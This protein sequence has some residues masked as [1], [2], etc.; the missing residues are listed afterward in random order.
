[1][2]TK[3]ERKT[4]CLI[5]NGKVAANDVLRAAVARQREAGHRIDVRVTWEKGDARR[6]V[7]ETG[8]VN[9]LIAAGGAAAIYAVLTRSST[10]G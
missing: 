7:S 6:F 1:M 3:A 2:K 10:N 9:L 8:E 5:L 4:V